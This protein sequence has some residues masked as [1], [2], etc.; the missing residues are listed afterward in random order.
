MLMRYAMKMVGLALVLALAGCG[1]GGDVDRF[2]GNW[3]PIDGTLKKVCPG[4]VERTEA[5]TDDVVWSNGAS[6]DLVTVT[7]L[8]PCRLKADVIAESAYVV[9][10]HHCTESDGAG[11]TATVTFSRYTFSI[12]PDGL[13]A[14]ESA[15][16]QVTHLREGEA[17]SCSFVETGRY[18]KVDEATPRVAV[19]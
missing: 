12:Q 3:R 4:G 18:Q 19:R 5:M 6:S 14:L 9:P 11:G 16:G 2:V 13:T 10:G 17:T 15:T 8:M 1:G 7:S